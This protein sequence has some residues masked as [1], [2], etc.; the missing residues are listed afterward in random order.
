MNFSSEI[1]NLE[2]ILWNELGN[3]EDYIRFFGDAPVLK[4]I[5]SITKLSHEAVLDAFSEFISDQ[6]LNAKQIDFIKKIMDYVET[7]GYIDD[8]RVFEEDP[9]KT[10][11]SITQVF[12]DNMAVAR[13][14]IARI[15]Q[16]N[17]NCGVV[18]A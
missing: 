4:L 8:F 5:R 7:N 1:S 9:F 12:N 14:L 17:A 18:A 16:I 3:K 15:R 11:G 10:I 13:E 2:N 6:R